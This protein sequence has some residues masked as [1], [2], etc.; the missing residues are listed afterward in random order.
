M[1]I[2]AI[3]R[4]EWNERNQKRESSN[5]IKGINLKMERVQNECLKIR[6]ENRDLKTEL[7]N[8]KEEIKKSQIYTSS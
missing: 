4:E 3:I 8:V 6:S 5:D 2:G 7:T 1:K